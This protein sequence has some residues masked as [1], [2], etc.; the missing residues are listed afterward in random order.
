LVVIY[1]RTELVSFTEMSI[2]FTPKAVENRDIVEND[3]QS[4]LFYL[5]HRNS[6]YRKLQNR[7]LLA[8]LLATYV[9]NQGLLC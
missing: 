3:T 6:T 9:D 7:L 8:M 4:A 2:Q 1:L 5:K